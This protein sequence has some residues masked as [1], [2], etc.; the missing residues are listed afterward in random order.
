M[1]IGGAALALGHVETRPRT[2]LAGGW[3]S[4]ELINPL[5]VAVV[6]VPVVF[7]AQMLQHGIM[8]N[9]WVPSAI[10][11]VHETTGEQQLVHLTV[12]SEA[13]A[14]ARGE[15]T[16]TE[17]GTYRMHT[18]EMGPEV[19]LGRVVALLPGP[20][21]VISVLYAGS[22]PGK[23]KETITTGNVVETTILDNSF[24]DATLE[25]TAG[26]TVSWTNS[27]V[28]PH[29]V[30]FADDAIE[31]SPMLHQGESFTV[32]FD[33][34]GEYTYVCTPHPHMAGVVRVQEA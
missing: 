28:L 2:A 23:K 27:S 9:V 5:Q 3:A 32:T 21:E 25:V 14:I 18:A 10:S 17:E 15:V 29:Q 24:A 8:P 34:A 13:Y 1:V 31:A 11:F 4:L 20:D 16:F 19:D 7:D 26:T 30:K 6:G 12:L 33:V 22:D